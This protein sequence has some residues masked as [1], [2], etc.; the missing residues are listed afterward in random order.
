MKR[1]V[2]KGTMGF[3]LLLPVLSAIQTSN[4]D[5]HLFI[6]RSRRNFVIRRF[7]GTASLACIHIGTR[8]YIGIHFGCIAHHL[9][10]QTFLPSCWIHFNCKNNCWRNKDCTYLVKLS[11]SSHCFLQKQFIANSRQCIQR[12]SHAHERRLVVTHCH[13]GNRGADRKLQVHPRGLSLG[14]CHL[15]S[16]SSCRS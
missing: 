12:R 13:C 5:G 9:F 6:R 16:A 10:L 14:H 7:L 11:F 1:R 4:K 3:P 15:R 8:L 2:S